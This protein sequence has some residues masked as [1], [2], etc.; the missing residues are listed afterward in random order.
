MISKVTQQANLSQ[1]PF[2][3]LRF[4]KKARDKFN[5]NGFSRYL[6]LRRPEL[7]RLASPQNAHMTRL[8]RRIRKH[9]AQVLAQTSTAFRHGTCVP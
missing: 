1:S 3:K 2:G 7:R 8:T 9:P 5:S 4:L 6:V